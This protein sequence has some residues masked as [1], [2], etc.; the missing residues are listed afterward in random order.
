MD[1]RQLT[2]LAE[3][4]RCDPLSPRLMRSNRRSVPDTDVRYHLLVGTAGVDRAEW[5]KVVQGLLDAIPRR[6]KAALSR[7]IGF[8]EKTIDR[9]LQQLVDVDESSI[10]QVAE[11][12]GGNAMELLIQVGYYRRD[13][14]PAP[15]VPPEDAWIVDVIKASDISPRQKEL[16]IAVELDRAK[17]ERDEKRRR[18]EEQIQLVGG[19]EERQ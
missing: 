7:L 5:A 9:W 13:E 17:R 18:I 2:R 10:R 3:R 19:S 6:N 16:L 15:D 1:A 12:T 8:R 11:R 14:L 4:R